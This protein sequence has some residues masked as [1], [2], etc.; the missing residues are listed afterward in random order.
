M[1]SIVLFTSVSVYLI[2]TFSHEKDQNAFK[3]SLQQILRSPPFFR[4]AYLLSR[5]ANLPVGLFIRPK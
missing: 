1:L 2:K 3:P 5:L 4:I